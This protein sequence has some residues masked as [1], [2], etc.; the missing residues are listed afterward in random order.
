[1]TKKNNKLCIHTAS[2]HKRGY[3]SVMVQCE[4]NSVRYNGLCVCDTAVICFNE[5]VCMC[6]CVSHTNYT[7][8]ALKDNYNTKSSCGCLFFEGGRKGVF[9]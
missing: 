3:Q 7:V 1:M 6:V 5:E 2:P 8:R 9:L 4:N